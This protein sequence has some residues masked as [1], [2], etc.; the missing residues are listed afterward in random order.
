MPELSAVLRNREKGLFIALTVESWELGAGTPE[1]ARYRARTP[2]ARSSG[3]GAADKRQRRRNSVL[4]TTVSAPGMAVL[5]EGGG[6]H[7]RVSRRMVLECERH[8]RGGRG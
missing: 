5:G 3:S 8:S 1:K 6:A 7:G 2:E 4:Q